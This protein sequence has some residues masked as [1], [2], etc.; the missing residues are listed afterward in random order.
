MG[1]QMNALEKIGEWLGEGKRTALAVVISKKGSAMRH[2]GAKMAVS[3]RM[4]MA[5]S[6]SGGCVEGAVVEE[7]LQAMESGEIRVMDYGI[8]DE[9]AWSVGLACG[10]SIQVLV[11]PIV[12][13]RIG[14][15]EEIIKEILRCTGNRRN[16]S[17]VTVLSGE[18]RGDVRIFEENI[19]EGNLTGAPWWKT[20]LR[21]EI[22]NLQRNEF[23]QMVV[24]SGDEFFIDVY[25]PKPRL[26]LIGAAHISI[27][28][29]KMAKISGFYTIVIDP[30]RA[31]ATR[32]RLPEADELIINWPDEGLDEIEINHHDFLLLLSHD[33]KLDLP[34][35]AKALDCKVRYIGMLSSR[36]TRDARYEK[37]KEKGYDPASLKKIHAP[38][39]LD[40]GARKPEEIALSILAEI[41]AVRYGK[42]K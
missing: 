31:F 14:L 33:D 13:N 7:A 35:L 32:E 30:R 34:A 12:E 37:M 23:S 8:P 36:Q 27:P 41:T 20:E 16:F 3:S 42:K 4:E 15:T 10:G 38:V 25:P 40:I 6:V 29:I 26:I 28:L 39:G 24:V 1:D 21:T 17:S 5:G 18:S 11:Q 19:T 22:Q 2:T 9:T